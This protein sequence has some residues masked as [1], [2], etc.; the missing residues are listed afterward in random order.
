M[1]II[2]K[3]QVSSSMTRRLSDGSKKRVGGRNVWVVYVDAF[4]TRHMTF[5]FATVLL[6]RFHPKTKNYIGIPSEEGPDNV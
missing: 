4:A 3:I 1:E 5:Q 2:I 6:E